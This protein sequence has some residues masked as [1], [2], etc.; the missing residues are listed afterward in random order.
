LLSQ[1]ERLAA[2]GETSI[3]LNI[4]RCLH[5][6]FDVFECDA[7]YSVCPVEAIQ[8][9]KLPELDTEAC[10][11]CLACLPVCPTDAF[12]AKDAF[13]PLLYCTTRIEANSIELL[14][15]LNNNNALVTEN[16]EAGIRIKGCLAGLG[17]GALVVLL[18]LDYQ[19]IVLRLDS[20]GEC[21]WGSLQ[22][23]IKKHYSQIQKLLKPWH[24]VGTLSLVEDPV[25]GPTDDR[26]I[27]DTDNP[28]LSRRALFKMVGRQGQITIARALESSET[29]FNKR[30]GRDRLRLVKAVE[31]L[32]ER[33]QEI[34]S[35]DLDPFG[36]AVLS[37]SEDCSACGVCTRVCPTET[38]QL[39]IEENRFKLKF[40]PQHC[41]G[42]EIC[43]H[44][45][46]PG[47]IK[48]KHSSAFTDVF[49]N[50]DGVILHQGDL[51]ACKKCK[52]PFAFK[53]NKMFCSLCDFRQKNPF[54]SVIN[55]GIQ[56]LITSREISKN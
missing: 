39:E 15:Q 56:A 42:C 47:A 43:K 48:I 8:A 16:A 3:S 27:W 45:C 2:I 30:P 26:P 6:K 21:P 1:T 25:L 35:C 10:Q 24:K 37:I 55:P 14:C 31:M 49:G 40:L 7:C 53:E 36:F 12:S 33:E 54:G 17:V 4:S 28:P 41:I 13:Q 34:A 38:L 52:Q 5:S 46:M 44:L 18:I 29:N 50:P 9:S 51:G 11:N 22:P 20:C 19:E 32:S 23:R